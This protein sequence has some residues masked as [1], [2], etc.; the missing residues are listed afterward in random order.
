MMDYGEK[1]I[2]ALKAILLLS[3]FKCLR[4]C[5]LQAKSTASG[6]LTWEEVDMCAGSFGLIQLS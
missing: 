3:L 6:D 1:D 5:I 4:V 2:A